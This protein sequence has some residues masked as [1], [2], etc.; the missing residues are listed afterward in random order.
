MF[1]IV[2]L[3]TKHLVVSDAVLISL[4]SFFFFFSSRR[5]HTRWPRDWSSDVCSSDL[6][7][8]MLPLLT[9]I[10]HLEQIPD[11]HIGLSLEGCITAGD[12]DATLASQICLILAALA[13]VS[14]R[15]ELAI[16]AG[17]NARGQLPSTRCI[18]E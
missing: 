4:L 11:V 5:R 6:E 2:P 13:D 16:L 15:Q 18:N 12:T 14:I 17:I 10:L 8:F 3:Q 7:N 1:L 9:E